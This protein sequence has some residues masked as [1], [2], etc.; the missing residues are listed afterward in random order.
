MNQAYLDPNSYDFAG[1]YPA[2]GGKDLIVPESLARS[3]TMLVRWNIRQMVKGSTIDRI[4]PAILTAVL[5]IPGLGEFDPIEFQIAPSIQGKK[6]VQIVSLDPALPYKLTF[7]QIDESVTNSVLEFYISDIEMG[8]FN[9]PVNVTTDFSPVIAA[10]AATSA[11]EV[12]SMQAQTAAITRKVVSEVETI[13]TATVW[14]NTPANHVAVSPDATRFGGSF[15]N[16]GNRPLAVDKY[17][18]IATKT[19]AMQADGLIQ[20]GGTYTFKVDEAHMGY[21]IYALTSGGTPTVAINLQK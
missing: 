14:S 6:R 20:P 16:S 11:T 10:I 17:L 9:N 1:G 4:T 3:Q 2:S 21:L 8:E 18:D 12:S 5:E 15:Y 7:S 13:Y 19:P